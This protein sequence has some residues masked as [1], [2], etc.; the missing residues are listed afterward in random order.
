MQVFNGGA[1]VYPNKH[2]MLLMAY[3]SALKMLQTKLKPLKYRSEVKDV[4][5]LSSNRSYKDNY[6]NM[7][8]IFLNV[9]QWT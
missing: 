6:N 8:E 1:S 2:R 9:K 3:L 7:F 4:T 5:V